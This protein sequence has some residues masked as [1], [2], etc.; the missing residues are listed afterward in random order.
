MSREV[1]VEKLQAELASG[2]LRNGEN[3]YQISSKHQAKNA[4]TRSKLKAGTMLPQP[5]FAIPVAGQNFVNFIP[6]CIRVVSV[7]QVA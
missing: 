3:S 2:P 4:F 6:E 7:M 1:L 5:F